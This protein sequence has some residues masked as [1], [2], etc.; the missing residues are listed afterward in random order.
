MI[1]ERFCFKRMKVLEGRNVTRWVPGKTPRGVSNERSQEKG[2]SAEKQK[3]SIRTTT[4]EKTVP[5]GAG[6]ALL[7]ERGQGGRGGGG[8]KLSFQV[9]P[10][11][12]G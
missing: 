11:K 2:P 9:L 1:K 4:L 6:N 12:L 3:A 8:P 7:F 10:E 5:K